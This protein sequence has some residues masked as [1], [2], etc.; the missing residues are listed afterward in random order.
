MWELIRCL[1][2]A[3]D[4][5]L[6]VR[7]QTNWRDGDCKRSFFYSNVAIEIKP[8]SRVYSKTKQK[9]HFKKPGLFG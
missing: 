2:T 8:A 7:S 1:Q 9:I 3:A 5:I 4:G 6:Q